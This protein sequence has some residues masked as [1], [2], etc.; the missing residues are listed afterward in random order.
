MDYIFLALAVMIAGFIDSLAGGGGLITLPAYLAFG[1]DPAF[2]LGTNKVSSIMGTAISAYKFRKRIKIS[3]K[4]VMALSA[5]ALLYSAVGAGLSRLLA[6]AHLKYIILIIAPVMAYFIIS[7]KNLGRGE[8]RRAIG[9]KKSNRAARFIAGGVAC[10]DGIL[11]PGAGTMYAVF[12]T[13]YAGFEMVQATAIA[14]VLNFCSNL[15]ALAVFICL[16][17]VNFKLGIAMG[18]AAVVGNTAGVYAGKKYGGALIKPMIV[19]VCALIIF[20]FV[21]DNYR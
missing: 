11:G 10:Y 3:R 6:P 1:L 12:L 14:K 5:R 20:K 15:F 7:N 13:K 4:L 8:N 2:I 21:W 18:C 9:I 17:A 16:G 19:F